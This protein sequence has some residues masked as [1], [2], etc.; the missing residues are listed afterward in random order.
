[1][2]EVKGC[3]SDIIPFSL[4]DGPGIRTTVFLKGCPLRCP[5]CH[6]PETQR[7]APVNM[8]Y[9]EKCV[10][11][12]R[13]EL[14]CPKK[15]RASD[16]S[17]IQDNSACD[18]CG[19]CVAACPV[20]A[21][22]INGSYMTP[23]EV[24]KVTIK[25]HVFYKKSGGGV[26]ISGGEALMQEEFLCETARLHKEAGIDLVLETCGFGRWSALEKLLPHVSLFLFDWKITDSEE[27]KRLTGVDNTLIRENLEKLNAAGANIILRCPIIPGCNDT[28]EH[29][30]GIG[31]L[32]Q[33]L[34]C[35]REVEIL[36][37]HSL[38]N[39]KRKKMGLQ[40][41]GFEP[42]ELEKSQ[43]W[44]EILQQYCWVPVKL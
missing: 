21:N 42:P 25:D 19:A 41:D 2:M 38:G 8:Y 11:C 22:K 17:W 28:E 39:S 3:I 6:N 36:P 26:T 4:H 35:I 13:C 23:E 20:G 12:G 10:H 44:K 29:F 31:E 30:C 43:Q 18:G 14:A 7:K 32:T 34:E 9:Q 15:L 40:Q 1:M 16:G 5:W 24:L 27:H 33:R 37:Y